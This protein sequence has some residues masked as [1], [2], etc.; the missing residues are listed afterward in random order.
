[1]YNL[2]DPLQCLQVDPPKKSVYKQN[3]LT[4]IRAF[5]EKELRSIAETNS[6]IKYFHVGTI[7]LTG[8]HHPILS[9]AVTTTEVKALRPAVKM[10]LS[11]YLTFS[12]KDSQSGG[13]AHCRLC[14]TPADQSRP[15]AEDIEHVLTRCVGTAE[16][17]EKKLAELFTI[18]ATA[19]SNVNCD[20]LRENSSTLTQ[21]ILDCSSN[22]LDND[23]RISQSDPVMMEIYITARH[24]INAI[25]CERTRKIKLLK[26]TQV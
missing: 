12:V 11:D 5:H 10:L 23:T 9:S 16:T 21:F 2:T 15:P 24:L 17:R 6:K 1:M 26:K 18:I 19:K 14:P 22:N 8:R 25:H 3:V 4:K 13:G 20:R 7:G